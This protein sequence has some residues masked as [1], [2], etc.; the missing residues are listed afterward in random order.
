MF[1]FKDLS[2]RQKIGGGLIAFVILF[3]VSFCIPLISAFK[4]S[5]YQAQIKYKEMPQSIFG[6]ELNAKILHTIALVNRSLFTKQQSYMDDAWKAFEEAKLRNVE[7]QKSRN[8]N[9]AE[10]LDD[11]NHLLT[12][13]EALLG[14][15]N[16]LTKQLDAK[17]ADLEKV[18]MSYYAVL[19]KLRSRLGRSATPAQASERSALVSETITVIDRAK[20]K[21]KD[22]AAV[23]EALT[24]VLENHKKMLA[25]AGQYDMAS[26]V[27][28]GGGY[29]QQY[30][31]GFRE[32]V[33]QNKDQLATFEKMVADADG[34]NKIIERTGREA[35]GRA[36][37]CLDGATSSVNDIFV[38]AFTTL[39]VM[40]LLAILLLRWFTNMTVKPIGKIESMISKLS[41]GD[42][43]Q[44]VD[45]DSNDEMGRMAVKLNEMTAKLRD[46]VKKIIVSA[47]DVNTS[48]N[49]MSNTANQMNQG[50]SEQSASTEEISSAIE[51][52][53]A[54]IAQNN[55]NAQQTEQIADNAL[56]NIRLT[57]DASQKSMEAMKD[58]AQKI[59]II[60]EIAFQTNILAL[61]AAVEAA[62]A[63]EQGKGFAVVAAEVRKLA[64]RSAKA[65]SE[66]D[67]VSHN[68][69]S[70]SE[71][72]S[73]LLRNIIPDIERTTALIRD[74]ATASNQQSAGIDQINQSMQNLNRVTQSN[75]ASA[76][77]MASTSEN[78]A[79]QSND[80][81]QAVSFFKTDE[82]IT[83]SRSRTARQTSAPKTDP[84]KVTI[85]GG[86]TGKTSFARQSTPRNDEFVMPT[87][88]PVKKTTPTR[89]NA[90]EK[91]TGGTFIDM[92]SD[93][94]DR[95]FE[96]F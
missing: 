22:E 81:K 93:D 12:D 65:A 60:D 26:E 29:I 64:E 77:E 63:G 94:K 30:I 50:A 78:L 23:K 54:R 44:N 96:S 76:E 70:V 72:A 7:L 61:N 68:A 52:M 39:A 1:T 36:S 35:M 73:E 43:T 45:I 58:I 2:I 85:S 24:K 31:N 53:T 42:L 18:K 95:E 55:E 19:E 49:E 5:A 11:I 59:S 38:I 47:E 3:A 51:E 16:T 14:K 67:Q 74:V 80:L 84:G 86:N 66:I 28:R 34:L 17:Y 27:E 57:N 33:A 13:Y 4:T 82:K 21:I 41:E 15:Y 83:D 71:K 75:A 89:Q 87:N 88:K 92:S 32:Y 6:N 69:V 25:F 91:K 79:V 37:Q 48:G 46:I 20:G 56:S 40:I 8:E 9:N 62:R 90:I 10:Q